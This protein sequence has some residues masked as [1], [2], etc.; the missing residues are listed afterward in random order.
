MIDM[1]SLSVLGVLCGEFS[2]YIQMH[3]SISS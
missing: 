1:F 3:S 2:R